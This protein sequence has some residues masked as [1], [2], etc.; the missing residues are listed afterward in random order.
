MVDGG[1]RDGKE[2]FVGIDGSVVVAF[3]GLVGFMPESG[4]VEALGKDG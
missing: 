2:I 3:V 1:E 4:G